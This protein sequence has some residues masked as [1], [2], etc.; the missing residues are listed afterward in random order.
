MLAE[1]GREPQSLPVTL[2]GVAADAD[3]L[4]GYR[5]HG[6]ARVI[7]MLPSAKRDEILPAL[8]R[9]AELIRK[10]NS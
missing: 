5:D 8:D 9:W 3:R 1:A 7:V 10:V 4:R 6:I 2:F